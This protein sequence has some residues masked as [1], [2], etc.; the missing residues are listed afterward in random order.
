[1]IQAFF[2]WEYGFE[3]LVA[4]L[5]VVP[6]VVN[7]GAAVLP[8]ILGGIMSAAS[9][10]LRPRELLRA[11]RRRPWVP[12]LLAALAAGAWWLTG[13]IIA[14]WPAGPDNVRGSTS[15]DW[16]QLATEA[17]YREQVDSAPSPGGATQPAGG[18]VMLGRGPA[19]CGYGQGPSP[20]NLLPLWRHR[21]HDTMYLSSPAVVGKWVYGASCYLDPPGNY[22]EIFCLD[23]ETGGTRWM[24][25]VATDPRT[26]EKVELKGFFSSPAVTA[27]GQ[28]VVI[29]QGLHYDRNC[30]LLCFEA[31]TGKLYWR[32][33][34][35]L[36]I[37]SSP[38][39]LGDLAVVGAGAVENEKMQA[40]GD[41]GF[42]LGVRISDGKV[43]WRQA[44]NDPESSPALSADG[45]CYIGSG[46]NGSE[47]VALRTAGEAELQS[48]KL[49]RVLW[50]A[51]TPYPATGAVTLW[52]K[53][54]LIG[55][56]NGDYVYADPNPAGA[57]LAFDRH[58]GKPAWQVQLPDAA[59]GAVAAGPGRA[60]VPVRNGEIVAVDLA[61]AGDRGA[62]AILWRSRLSARAAVLA[63]VA[64]TGTHVYAVSKDGYLSVLRASDGKVVERHYVNDLNKPGEMGLSLSTPTVVGGRIYV[65]SETGGLL[66]LA[67]R[68]AS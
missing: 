43:L 4:P 28:Y 47:L 53:W 8:A 49:P 62:D 1:M 16:A 31:A 57:V 51:K 32:V 19:R 54:V 29:G 9:I 56:G 60:I 3:N 13:W 35:P 52:G 59:L 25:D 67:G 27:D 66:C 65:G 63:G 64:Y 36:H 14:A 42:V 34:T 22:G 30:S 21:A 41:P 58:T 68:K 18:A 55:C 5:A 11:V 40:V 15:I 61:R 50:R 20:R 45:I 46:F 48:R 12:V 24:V 39:V 10:L 26:R 38:A 33:P 2:S 6:I 17:I 7:V 44:V 23:A 37:E